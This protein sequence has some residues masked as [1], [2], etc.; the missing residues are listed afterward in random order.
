MSQKKK[1]ISKAFIYLQIL[2]IIVKIIFFLY[3]EA[4]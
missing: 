3:F 2:E 1:E 4:I